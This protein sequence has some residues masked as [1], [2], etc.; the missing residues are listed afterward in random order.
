M[1][2]ENA[3]QKTRGLFLGEM[4]WKKAHDLVI[5]WSWRSESSP[6]TGY[7]ITTL[8]RRRGILS[9]VGDTQPTGRYEVVS[10]E[11]DRALSAK[12]IIAQ[13]HPI[14]HAS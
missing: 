13:F 7:L 9:V 6:C 1:G 4:K 11:L 8:A 5:W 10:S 14:L 2:D 3:G 12:L